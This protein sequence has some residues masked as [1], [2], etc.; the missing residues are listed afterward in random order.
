MV[1]G[2]LSGTLTIGYL[3]LESTLKPRH[4]ERLHVGA[5]LSSAAE[6]PAGSQLHLPAHVNGSDQLSTTA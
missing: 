6:W 5:L 1:S 3:L 2:S 4:M